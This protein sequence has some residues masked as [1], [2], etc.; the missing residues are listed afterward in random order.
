MVLIRLLALGAST[1]SGPIKS[2]SNAAPPSPVTIHL[3]VP[4]AS[5]T[6]VGSKL[7]GGGACDWEVEGGFEVDLDDFVVACP[8]C[9][10]DEVEW[11]PLPVLAG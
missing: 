2:P 6:I 3:S 4:T 10:P 7:F 8:G 1:M 11:V 5:A 9:P